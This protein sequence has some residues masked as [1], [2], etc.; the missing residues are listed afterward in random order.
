MSN[1]YSILY[2]DPPWD[3]KGQLQH[4][5][6]GGRDTGGA[7]RH[8]RTM[9]LEEMSCLDIGRFCAD[10]CLLFMWVTNP[11]LDQGIDLGKAWGFDW[12]TVAFVWDKGKTNPGF[13]TLSQC[14][15]CL[16]MKRGRIPRPRGSRKE[17]Q[18]VQALRG[19]HS[20]KPEE[21][22]QR[23]ER[24]FPDH[25]RLELFARC[26]H[27][28]WDCLGDHLGDVLHMNTAGWQTYRD[29]L[30]EKR[31]SIDTILT[32]LNAFFSQSPK[33]KAKA[34]TENRIIERQEGKRQAD[35]L[36]LFESVEGRGVPSGGIEPPASPLPRVRSTPELR[37]R[38]V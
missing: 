12:A 34:K 14:E 17:R 23:I 19:P 31:R 28:G 24:M 5:G 4:N 22:R 30:V 21:V 13:Y 33:P 18:L 15:L 25:K 20:Q 29:V 6:E 38:M 35:S 10:D 26:R 37:R 27:K 1:T 36:P 32:R 7:V 16:V 2:A 8:Y 3:Y 11:H 9:T